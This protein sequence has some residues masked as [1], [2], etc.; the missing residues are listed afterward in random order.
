MVQEVSAADQT[1]TRKPGLDSL[2]ARI[3][4]LIGPVRCELWFGGAGR[5][6]CSDSE[7]VFFFDSEF[8]LNRVQRH[9]GI[10]LRQAVEGLYGSEV[11]VQFS[12]RS[13]D[14]VQADQ[15]GQSLKPDNRE[16]PPADETSGESAVAEE[17]PLGINGVRDRVRKVSLAATQLAAVKGNG[18]KA[19]SADADTGSGSGSSNRR[20]Q[21]LEEFWFGE[22]NQLIQ[23]AL[24][25]NFKTPGHFSPLLIYG[26]TGVGKSHLLNAI[27]RRFRAEGKL[28]ICI[29]LTAEQFLNEFVYGLRK[30]GLPMFRRKFRDLDL[31]A[32]DDVHFLAGKAATINEINVT[33]D[34]LSKAGKQVILTTDR[35]PAELNQISKELSGRL[36]GGLNCPLRYP[37]VEGRRWILDS[38]CRQR[39]WSF[40]SDVLEL[41]ALGIERDCRR[42]NG[43]LNR[44][45]A[46]ELASGKSTTKES[47]ERDLKD[48]IGSVT[49][50]TTLPRIEQLV[51]DACG[52]PSSELR[53]ESRTKRVS[54]ARMLAMWLSRQHTNNALSE[55]GDYFGGRSHSTVVAAQKRIEQ[56][57]ESG[58]KIELESGALPLKEAV[59]V[60][61][62]RLR[63]G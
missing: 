53:S 44:L 36:Q 32:I 60:L 51:C 14:S 27:C 29:S 42:L 55:I 26:P 35:M 47:A 38:I 24:A 48:L 19:A 34:H 46:A 56:W 41:V 57:L 5:V 6:L 62:R 52:I 7:V 4:E 18:V 61:A 12:V 45:R 22:E 49:S 2:L 3:A 13:T 21:T 63:V 43:A 30:S 28:R 23:K 10:Q 39:G 11:G 54:T 59:Q 33:L 31:L 25:E 37:G 20:N 1:E 58:E 16:V 15:A 50:V 9:H 40:S 8:E 17:R